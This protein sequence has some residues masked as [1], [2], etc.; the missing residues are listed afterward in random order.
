LF[1]AAIASVNVPNK[2]NKKTPWHRVD[3]SRSSSSDTTGDNSSVDGDEFD[4][5]YLATLVEQGAFDKVFKA[6]E[7][8]IYSIPNDAMTKYVF[9]AGRKKGLPQ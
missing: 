2:S 4:L 5:L 3:S 1:A 8:L 9:R 6:H 7:R